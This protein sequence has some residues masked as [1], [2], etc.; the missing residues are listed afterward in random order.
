LL[1]QGY[2]VATN[3]KGAIEVV[4]FGVTLIS[5]E[6]FSKIIFSLIN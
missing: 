3:A 1:Y 5:A 6:V 2:K 4:L